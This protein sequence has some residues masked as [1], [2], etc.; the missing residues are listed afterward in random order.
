MISKKSY[1]ATAREAVTAAKD[2]IIDNG[3]LTCV[4]CHML[5][6]GHPVV[7]NVRDW[8]GKPYLKHLCTGEFVRINNGEPESK[9]K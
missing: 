4:K 8:I 7:T 9:A 1:E 5:A 2:A 3:K 6:Q